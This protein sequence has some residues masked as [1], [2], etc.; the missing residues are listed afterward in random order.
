[1]EKYEDE[2]RELKKQV[3][4]LTEENGRLKAK[5]DEAETNGQTVM[6][7]QDENDMLK[8]AA[9]KL[10]TLE[11]QLAVFKEKVRRGL[12]RGGVCAAA[13]SDTVALSPFNQRRR[14]RSATSTFSS[15]RNRQPTARP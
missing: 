6:L 14:R 1:M 8:H 10:P 5:A 12:L 13:F 15:R 2:E 7:L 3:E 4:L 9:A 11:K